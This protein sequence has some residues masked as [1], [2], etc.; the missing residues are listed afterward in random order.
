[1]TLASIR[2]RT[3]ELLS[4]EHR[5]DR[6]SRWFNG[7]IGGLIVGNML[8]TVLESVSSIRQGHEA[9]FSYFETLSV[10]AFSIEYVAR[11]WSAAAG[12][13]ARVRLMFRPMMLVDLLAILPWY[14]P[15]A[16]VDLRVLRALRLFRVARVMR[17][18]PYVSAQRTLMRMFERCRYELGATLALGILLLLLASSGMYFVEREAQPEAFS[19]IPAAMWWAVVTLTTVGYGDTYPVTAAGQLLG[20]VIATLGIGL[21][22]LPTAILGASFLEALKEERQHPEPARCP[23]CGADLSPRSRGG[24]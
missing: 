2:A 19:S 5:A 13:G 17:L 12:F 22:A 8:A 3:H 6:T 11:L 23:R 9:W 24:A 14:L 1:M 21:F 18:G 15:R 4:V 16:G 7:L 20:G 10:V